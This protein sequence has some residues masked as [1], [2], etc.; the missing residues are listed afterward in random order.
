VRTHV[1]VGVGG[2]ACCVGA[3]FAIGI[4]GEGVEV[5]VNSGSSAFRFGP[6]NPGGAPESPALV[7]DTPSPMPTPVSSGPDVAARMAVVQAE[8]D[9]LR[10]SSAAL[11]SEVAILQPA[12]YAAMPTPTLAA[13]VERLRMLHSVASTE[14]AR[15]A[16]M[17]LVD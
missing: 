15:R 10:A 5:D 3:Q 9:R 4:I 6:G 16:G 8:L 17:M 7:L 11:A 12:R 14:R 1:R 2:S 13:V